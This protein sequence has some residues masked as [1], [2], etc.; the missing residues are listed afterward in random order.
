[1]DCPYCN[2]EM[3]K[4]YIVSTFALARWYAQGDNPKGAFNK[5]GVRLTNDPAIEKQIIKSYHCGSCKK[6]IIDVP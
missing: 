1:M 5:N 3:Q 4:G 2:D 6:I